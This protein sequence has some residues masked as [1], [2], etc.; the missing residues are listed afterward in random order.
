MLQKYLSQLRILRLLEVHH[1]QTNYVTTEEGLN[2]VERWTDL[3][4]LSLA[5]RAQN[6]GLERG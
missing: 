3:I 6:T 4:D 5:S 1:S 2:F